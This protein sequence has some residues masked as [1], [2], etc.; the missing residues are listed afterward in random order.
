MRIAILGSRGIPAKYGAFEVCA[1]R[2]ALG[3]TERGHQIT[4]YCPADQEYQDAF[5]H[6]VRLVHIK[7]PRAA[8]GP[9]VYDVS[10]LRHAVAEKPAAI[11]MLGYGASPFF[12]LTRRRGIP[13]IV[14]TDGLEWKRS[15]WPPAVRVYFRLAERMAV[16]WADRLVSDS[17]AIQQYYAE[18]YGVRSTYIAYGTEMPQVAPFDLSA[19]GLSAGGYYIVVMRLEPENSIRAIVDGFRASS[20]N[21]QLVIIG[22]TTPFFDREVLPLVQAD[23]RIRYLGSIYDRNEVFALRLHAYAYLHGH[24][25]GG[26]N[27]SL[28]EA[29]ACGNFVIARDV[30]FNREVVR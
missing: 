18:E 21:R 19:R 17:L 20:S 11:I 28:L 14:N 12:F 27:P 26:T 10:C 16:R 2:L 4:V 25:V 15:K 23:P 13:L 9:L 22:P 7:H 5:Y 8:V 3:F 30:P 6:S 1:E 24:T 29:L